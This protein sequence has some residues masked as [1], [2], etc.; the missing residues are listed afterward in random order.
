MTEAPLTRAVHG[1]AGHVGQGWRTDCYRAISQGSQK[2]HV[3]AFDYRGFGYSTGSPTE[4]GLIADGAAAVGWVLNEL[5]V[6]PNQV[7]L[8]GQSLGT[9]V[10]TAVAEEFAT[11]KRIEFAGLVL[12]SPFTN[13]AKL[14]STYSIA[15]AIPIFSPLGPYPKIKQ[16][17][18][19]KIIDTWDTANRLGTFVRASDRPRVYLIHSKDDFDIHWTH[20]TTLFYV[21]ANATS[22]EGLSIKQMNSVRTATD[23]EPQ[24]TQF[25][26]KAAGKGMDLKRVSYSL[27]KH[28]G[29]FDMC[30]SI[31]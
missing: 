29:K 9:A 28:G 11:L 13:L 8:V 19:S 4:K 23:L 31:E 14:L 3:I 30:S 21:A 1:N 20:S 5:K 15:R 26:W 18:E 12:I 7:A 24:G 10:A 2:V 27:M 22:S 25:R 6:K 16:W 17:F